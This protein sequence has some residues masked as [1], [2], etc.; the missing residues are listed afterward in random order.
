MGNQL[1]LMQDFEVIALIEKF[2]LEIG[3]YADNETFFMGE[4][5]LCGVIHGMTW[6]RKIDPSID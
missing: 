6:H 3:D 1:Q 2:R 4:M 5:A